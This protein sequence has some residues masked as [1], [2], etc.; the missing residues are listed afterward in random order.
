[1]SVRQTTIGLFHLVSNEVIQI[2]GEFDL[3]VKSLLLRRRS[4]SGIGQLRLKLDLAGSLG[5]IDATFI[6]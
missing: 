5:C 4:D 3:F 1:L 6:G 2:C